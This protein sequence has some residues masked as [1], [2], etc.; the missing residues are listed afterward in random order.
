MAYRTVEVDIDLDSFS[1]Q[2]LVE[3]LENRGRHVS[4]NS[5]SRLYRIFELRQQGRDYQQELDQLIWE[6]LGRIA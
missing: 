1:D 3:E 6:S 4:L 5:L 2:D